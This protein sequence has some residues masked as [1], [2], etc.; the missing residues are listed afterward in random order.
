MVSRIRREELQQE[1][2]GIKTP[3]EKKPSPG[4][5]VVFETSDPALVVF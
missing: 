1:L 4:G 2:P 5:V 3:A